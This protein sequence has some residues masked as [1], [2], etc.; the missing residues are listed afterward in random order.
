MVEELLCLYR[1]VSVE[2]VF[3][4]FF[5]FEYVFVME[6][7]MLLLLIEFN[8]RIAYLCKVRREICGLFMLYVKLVVLVL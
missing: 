7:D 3:V 8:I 5:V 2:M 4:M 6:L 1:L